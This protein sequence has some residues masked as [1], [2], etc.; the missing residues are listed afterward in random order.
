[1]DLRSVFSLKKYRREPLPEG[2]FEG[3]VDVHSHLLPGV[4]DGFQTAEDTIEALHTWAAA[5][6]RGVIFTPH[7]ME[8][9]KANRR[10]AIEQRFNAFQQ[11]VNSYVSS[12][13]LG[14]AGKGLPT[15]YLAAEYMVDD[16]FESHAAD[17]Y[18]SLGHDSGWV[19]TE[20]SYVDIHPSHTQ[21]L[22]DMSLAGY[23][24]VIA[25]PERYQY[26]SDR[27]YESWKR[28]GYKFQLNLL[29]L[30]GAYGDAAKEKAEWM[31]ADG[32]YDYVGSDVH[33]LRNFLS[34]LPKIMLTPR[35]TDDLRL[36]LEN[37]TS[38]L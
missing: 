8:G 22:Y 6:V 21:L 29:S 19:L 23:Q 32:M 3:T 34:W 26:A 11:Q 17:G 38:L 37:N 12:L 30:S 27:R 25:H 33:N 24:P 13:S 20:T 5:G 1:M 15:C 16:G 31:L 10:S 9:Y 28:K 18:L 14:E 35:Q 4:D 36:L 7:F 2:I